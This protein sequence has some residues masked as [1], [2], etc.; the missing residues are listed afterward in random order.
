MAEYAK[1]GKGKRVLEIEIMKAVAI[2]GM[3][4]VHVYELTGLLGVATSGIPYVIGWWIC[5]FGGIFSAGAFMAAMGWGAAFSETH[6]PKIYLERFVKLNILGW[7]VNIYQQWIPMIICPEHYGDLSE[8]WYTILAVDIYAFAAL[9]TLYLALMKQLK[10][11][12]VLAISISGVLLGVC[13]FINDFVPVETISTGYDWLDT[14]IGLFIRENEFSY[15]PFISWIAFPVI[16]YWMGVAYRKSQN[17]TK[18]NIILGVT[19]SIAVVLSTVLMNIQNIP[20]AALDPYNVTD[21]EYYAMSSLNCLCGYGMI[22]LEFVLASG[23]L[24]L[25]KGVVPHV[26]LEMCKNVMHIYVAQ[27]L[28]IG[29]LAKEIANVYS[30]LTSIL[31]STVVLVAAYAYAV[32]RESFLKKHKDSGAIRRLEKYMFR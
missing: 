6:T 24:K 10:D 26:L 11:R 13:L 25:T 2:I 12:P 30:T 16:G 19:G 22:A 3:I 4:Y 18:Y 28:F 5:F 21:T 17:H 31:I 20:N 27:W 7:I 23:L 14:L 9:A 32:L 15:F 29:L 8:K 1:L